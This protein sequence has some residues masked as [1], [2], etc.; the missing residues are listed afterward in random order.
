MWRSDVFWLHVVSDAV[1]AIAYFTIP[2]A[3]ISFSSKRRDESFKWVL[4]IFSAFVL[5]CGITHLLGILTM[6]FPIYGVEG[7]MKA[8]TAVISIATAFAIWP[9]I[10]KALKIPTVKE[11]EDRVGQRTVALEL[12]NTALREENQQRAKAE[13]RLEEARNEAE[14]A[15][16]AKSS[17]LS[18]MVIAHGVGS[19]RSISLR[20][21]A[22]TSALTA[23]IAV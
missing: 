12:A 6:W 11:L 13:E 9:L 22:E 18:V 14:T 7:L 10:P 8:M 19:K 21:W 20:L 5:A 1:I 2:A 15:N 4:L 23:S 3:L 17:F 16:R